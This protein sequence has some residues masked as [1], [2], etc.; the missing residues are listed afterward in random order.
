M[1]KNGVYGGG[2]GHTHVPH[3]CGYLKRPG[4]SVGYLGSKVAGICELTDRSVGN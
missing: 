4:I 1:I 2:V 3:L